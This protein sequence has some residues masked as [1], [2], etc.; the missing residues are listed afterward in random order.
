MI[1]THSQRIHAKKRAKERYGLI[2]NRHDLR[3]IVDDIHGG[4]FVLVERQSHRISVYDMVVK[5][6]PVR[7]VY[8]HQRQTVVTFLPKETTCE[9]DSTPVV[10]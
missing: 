6:T 10:E 1:K 9:A 8:D 2:L 4:R 7:L 3:A 5:G